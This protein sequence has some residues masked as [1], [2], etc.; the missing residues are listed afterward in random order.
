MRSDGKRVKNTE[1]MYALIPYIMPKRYDALNSVTVHLPYRPI[2]D[3]LIQK[4][5]EGVRL[6]HMSIIIAAYLRCA[7]EFPYLNRFI[8]RKK[9][10]AH[11]DFTVSMVVLRPGDLD[12][13]MTKVT[14]GLTDTIFDVNRR[15]MS[16]PVFMVSVCSSVKIKGR[17][18]GTINGHGPLLP[19]LSRT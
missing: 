9:I 17:D 19:A 18:C 2:H 12:G 10:Y 14:L 7:A 8:M 16:K 5:K 15:I 6:S 4:R 11:N 13:T 1:P 3:Y